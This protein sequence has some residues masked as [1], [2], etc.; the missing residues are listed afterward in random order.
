MSEFLAHGSTPEWSSIER[1]RNDW[2]TTSLI[3]ARD[4]DGWRQAKVLYDNNDDYESMM[5]CSDLFS[6]AL[7]HHLHRNP[8]VPEDEV[9]DA[10]NSILYSSITRPPDGLSLPLDVQRNIR[11]A[12]TFV[13]EYGWQ[14]IAMGGSG[15]VD[16]LLLD[17]GCSGLYCVS[18]AT[19]EDSS[20]VLER[21]FAV[22]PSLHGPVK[23]FADPCQGLAYEFEVAV[24]KSDSGDEASEHFMLGVMS[25][26]AGDVL[27]A[28]SEF[29]DS[30]YLGHVP[31]MN[32]LGSVFNEIGDVI[33]SSTWYQRSAD[34]G[35]PF[36]MFG[37]GVLAERDGEYS[38]ARNWYLRSAEGGNPEGF[39]ALT[40]MAFNRGDSEEVRRFAHLGADEGQPFCQHRFAFI[41]YVD[42]AGDT[43]ILR[44][45]LGYARASANQD[46]P[47]GTILAGGIC[48]ALGDRIAA[49]KWFDRARA[50]DDPLIL[51]R[52]RKLGR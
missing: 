11:L 9:F 42:A 27:A 44:E 29:E 23:P 12:L 22:M 30:A 43:R 51:E 6:Y 28:L 50:T 20:G 35:D 5:M 45:A 46:N 36:G 40:Q 25:H 41:L 13:R 17:P 18:L 47:D 8:I 19:G 52:L 48:E 32:E 4:L 34:T 21:F 10:T 3:A 7:S 49:E 14:P 24:S 15:Q 2:P 1:V 16:G 39:A 26:A 38:A 33:Q 31:A 37:L